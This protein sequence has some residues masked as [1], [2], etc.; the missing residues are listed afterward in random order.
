MFLTTRTTP[1]KKRGTPHDVLATFGSIIKASNGRT[2]LLLN[3]GLT[4][5]R[6]QEL[7]STGQIDAAV[8]GM[9]WI[10]NPDLEK[11]IEDGSSINYGHNFGGFYAWKGDDVG[12]GYTS[13]ADAE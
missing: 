6:A 12:D 7:V 9:P 1:G 4:P 8:F 11:R 10:T 5:D 2:K 13:Y 3:S